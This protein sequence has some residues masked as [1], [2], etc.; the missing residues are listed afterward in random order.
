MQRRRASCAASKH[1][2]LLQELVLLPLGRPLKS[3]LV[4]EVIHTPFKSA[5]AAWSQPHTHLGRRECIDAHHAERSFELVVE[6]VLPAVG[7]LPNVFF[8]VPVQALQHGM[9]RA[10]IRCVRN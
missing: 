9:T 7:G 10:N 6:H 4:L 1:L 5:Q 8:D 3:R 2:R